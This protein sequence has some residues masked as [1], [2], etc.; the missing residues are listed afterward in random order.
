M[1][2]DLKPVDQVRVLVDFAAGEALHASRVAFWWLLAAAALLLL[3]RLL[4]LAAIGRERRAR[5]PGLPSSGRLWRWS[6]AAAALLGLAAYQARRPDAAFLVGRAQGALQAGRFADAA[7]YLE[8]VARWGTRRADVYD[9]L[10]VCY[11]R[12][13]RPQDAI[14]ALRRAEA[15]GAGRPERQ[16]VW[17]YALVLAGDQAGAAARFAEA[18]RVARSPAEAVAIRAERARLLGAAANP[19]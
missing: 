7:G 11:L 13:G 5:V 8:P 12:L 10:G 16:V 3:A 19:P 6:A 9:S 14:A 2:V 4:L 18:L 17:A 1:P 15:I